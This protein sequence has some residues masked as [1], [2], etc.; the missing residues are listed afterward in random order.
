MRTGWLKLTISDLAV[1][2]IAEINQLITELNKSDADPLPDKEDFKNQVREL[3][4]KGKLDKKFA[5][6]K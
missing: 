2:P 5:E 4:K 6:E 3:I 1:M